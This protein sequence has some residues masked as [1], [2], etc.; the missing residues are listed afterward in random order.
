MKIFF[1]LKKIWEIMDYACGQRLAPQL[2]GIIDK[3]VFFKELNIPAT[4]QKKLKHISS[5]TIDDRL[6][7]FKN[8]LRLKINSTTRPG[9]LL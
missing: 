6:K 9:S 1:W 3:L 8:E 7:R 2:A 5:T 4:T